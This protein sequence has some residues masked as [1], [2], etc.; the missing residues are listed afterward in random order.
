M[1]TIFYRVRER[2]T[3][4]GK[5]RKIVILKEREIV[6]GRNCLET[7]L[8]KVLQLLNGNLFPH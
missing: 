8:S 4:I 1:V 5:W 7:S 6:T 2:S 3:N